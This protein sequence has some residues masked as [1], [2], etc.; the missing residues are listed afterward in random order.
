M[1]RVTYRNRVVL[2]SQDALP[3]PTPSARLKGAMRALGDAL[4]IQRAELA[5]FKER[6][7]ELDGALENLRDGLDDYAENVERI[8]VDGLRDAARRLRDSTDDC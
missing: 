1:A 5:E 7:A 3:K 2:D 8:D 6:V 4:A